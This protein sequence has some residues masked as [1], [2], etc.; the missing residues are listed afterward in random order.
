M[1]DAEIS[2]GFGG[3]LSADELVFTRAK[4]SIARFFPDSQTLI[5]FIANTFI[6][7]VTNGQALM[8]VADVYGKIV[9]E[10]KVLPLAQKWMAGASTPQDMQASITNLTQDERFILAQFL[11]LYNYVK[12]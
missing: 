3:N 6:S 4:L 11:G 10:T 1:S 9:D 2:A 12:S 7:R 5:G 8:D